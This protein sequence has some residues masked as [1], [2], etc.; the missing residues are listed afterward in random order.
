M[1][2]WTAGYV[3]EI[4]YTFGYYAELNPLRLKLMFLNQGLVFPEIGAACELGF[5]QGLSTNLHAAAS[6]TKWHGTDFNPSQAGFAQ[7]LSNAAGTDAQLYDEAFSEF[8]ARSDLPQF[9]YIGLHGIWSWVSDENRKIIVEFIRTRLKVGGVVYISYNTQPGWGAF[10]P[11]RHLLCL[12]AQI[13]GSLGEGTMGRVEG[14]FEFADKLLATNPIYAQA[15][16][17]VADRVK[18]VRS[19]NRQYVAHEY[20]NRDWLPMHFADV[21]R[22]LETAK[23]QFACSAHPLDHVEAFSMTKDQ[24]DFVKSIGD[25][26]LRESVRDFMTNQQFRRDYWV[27]GTRKLNAIERM[28]LLYEQKVIL[29][30]ERSSISLKV[31]G[32]AGEAQLNENVYGP[33]LN[34]M[35]DHKPRTLGQIE[36]ALKDKNI[37]F[38]QVLQSALVLAGLGYFS[39]VQSDSVIAKVRKNTEKV[40]SYIMRKARGDNEVAFLASPVTGG[41]V[42]VVKFQQLFVLAYLQGKKQPTEWASFVWNIVKAQGRKLIKD[43]KTLETE[44]ENLAELLDQANHFSQKRLPILKA[45]MIA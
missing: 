25:Q 2:D 8:A 38:N 22:W 29:V 37:D 44:E 19:Q 4:G 34:L 7:E 40:N 27:K 20:F 10:A 45:L 42:S 15:N 24:Q 36:A 21:A 41:G 18:G 23:L 3:A 30:T 26:T 13:D 17:Q 16:P 6:I 11:M 14:A 31:T 39:A 28:E 43:G 12:H 35:A 33:L 5:G 9:D 1:S 32:P